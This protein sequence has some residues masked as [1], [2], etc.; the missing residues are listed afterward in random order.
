MVDTRSKNKIRATASKAKPSTANNGGKKSPAVKKSKST[1]KE[2]SPAPKTVRFTEPK[3]SRHDFDPNGFGY[4]RFN[5]P[6]NDRSGGV[7][8]G[9]NYGFDWRYQV[10]PYPFGP[11]NYPSF[12]QI[13]FGP[14]KQHHG[15]FAGS[16]HGKRA[17]ELSN[18]S[19]NGSTDAETSAAVPAKRI[20]RTKSSK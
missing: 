18:D 6:Y 16:K 10:P 2:E 11:F 8:Y 9:Q 5:F 19:S 1:N 15:N 13:G 3:R 7:G 4:P 14:Q 12:N 20:A 17:R